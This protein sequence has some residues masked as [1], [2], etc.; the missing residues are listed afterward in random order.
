MIF[1]ESWAVFQKK[2]SGCPLLL[3]SNSLPAVPMCVCVWHGRLKPTNEIEGVH[4][5]KIA[6]HPPPKGSSSELCAKNIN[7]NESILPSL[8]D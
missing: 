1:I 5:L 4:A 8:K 7:P 2:I 6:E 3:L